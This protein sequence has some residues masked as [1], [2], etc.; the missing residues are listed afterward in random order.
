[1]PDALQMP[2]Q[3][4]KGVGPR[5]AADFKRAGLLT[6]E[7]LLFRF[8]LRYEDRSHLQS[9]GSVRAGQVVAVSGEIL[10]AGLQATRRAGFRLFTALVQD[11]SGQIPAVWPNQTFLKDVIRPHQRVALYG[12]AEHWGSRG[13]Q[14]TDPEFE[15]LRETG[16]EGGPALHTGRIVP[17]YERTGRVT[18][19]MQR[20]LVW[21]ALSQVP[22]DLFDPVPADICV[23]ENWPQRRDALWSTHFPGPGSS[24]DLLNTFRTPAQ[25]RLIFEDFFVFQAGLA[26]RRQK[27][28][29]VRKALI[30]RVD[31]RVRQAAR[32]VLPFR[33]TEDQRHALAE[34]VHDM[35][36]GWPMQRLLQGDVG[37]GKTIVALLAAMVAME[38]GFQAAFMAPTELLAEQHFATLS[39][40]LAATRHR[41]TLLSG[42]ISPAERRSLLP[43]IARGDVHLI[44]GTHALVQQQVSFHA[45]ALVVIDEQHRFGVLQ[46]GMLA[47][48]G[49]HP[50]VLVMTATPIPRTLA[51]TQCGDMEVSVIR[52]LPPGRRPVRTLVIPDSRRQEVYDLVRREVADGRQVYVVY[53]LV[54][55]SEKVDLKAATAM[56]DHLARDIFP[57]LTVA[58]VHGRMKA[59]EKESVMR[60]FAAGTLPIMV[61]TAVVEV[62]VDV[63]NAS[64]MIVEHAERFGLSQLHQLRGRVG[65]GSHAST[66]VL[67]YQA[68]WSDEARAR[69]KVMAETTDGFVIAERD[70]QLRG[71]GDFFGTR[72]HGVPQLR[73]GDLRRDVDLLEIA[74]TEARTRVDAATLTDAAREYVERVWDRQ[75]GLIEVG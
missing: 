57:D 71:P 63:P 17:V 72:Q 32:A 68:P 7:D 15:I 25:R 2:L 37:A 45:L 61:A 30:S 9:I 13:L 44:V 62:G 19:N 12:K 41:V 59:G 74:F 52:E 64:L 4:L 55:E 56:A 69:L 53:P 20:R 35:Q 33:L 50:D 3:Y 66:C 1:M 26:L 49:L 39:R 73:A 60:A 70:L 42:K 51:L 18:T 34:I 36:Q 31:D 46:R 75:F 40:W 27:N 47:D 29:S 16:D 5:K 28:A 6:V 22:A 24:L 21:E 8:P 23:R 14:L 48:K 65:R 43:A 54:E 38:N 58:L 10:H 11:A 67:L